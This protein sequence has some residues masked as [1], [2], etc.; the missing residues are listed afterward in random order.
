M[1][2][3]EKNYRSSIHK[4]LKSDESVIATPIQ[5]FPSKSHL[6]KII[7]YAKN[8]KRPENEWTPAEKLID[9]KMKATA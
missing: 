5:K 4:M 6:Q 2:G 7:Q 1:A 8:P 9:G 3:R